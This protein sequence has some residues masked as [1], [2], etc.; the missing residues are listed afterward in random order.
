MGVCAIIHKF[1]FICQIATCY[2]AWQ[3]HLPATVHDNE[4]GM[5]FIQ[6]DT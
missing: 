3:F 5:F 1:K 6:M 2:L 4:K